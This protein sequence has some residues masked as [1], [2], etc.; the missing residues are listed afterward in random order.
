MTSEAQ[1]VARA[2]TEGQNARRGDLVRNDSTGEL[3]YVICGT[4]GGRVLVGSTPTSAGYARWERYNITI[5]A[6]QGTLI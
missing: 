6:H 3:A 2:A 4:S 1:L 5:Q